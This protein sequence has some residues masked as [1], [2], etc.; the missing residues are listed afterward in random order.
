MAT[1]I[2]INK[3]GVIVMDSD[4]SPSFECAE[5]EYT[6][7]EKNDSLTEE[8][9]SWEFTVPAGYIL[10]IITAGHAIDSVADFV[11][12]AGYSDGGD[13]IIPEFMGNVP[14]VEA[15]KSYSINRQYFTDKKVYITLTGAGGIG[16]ITANLILNK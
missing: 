5:T 10:N 3:K 15:G 8:D 9:G 6:K 14:L 4:F 12:K 16:S 1:I 13:D 7:T 2:P 11:F